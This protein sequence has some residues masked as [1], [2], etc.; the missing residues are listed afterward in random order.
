MIAEFSD[1][2][3]VGRYVSAMRDQLAAG[4]LDEHAARGAHAIGRGAADPAAAVLAA[5]PEHDAGPASSG[6]TEI[7]SPFFSRS[8]AVSLLQTSL[9][10]EARKSG[11]VHRPEHR[12]LFAHIVGFVE[13]LV[14][15]ERF[16][17]HDGEWVSRVAEATLDRLARGNHPFNSTPAE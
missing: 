13:S 9:E 11:A 4:A 17:P 2:D 15:P 5:L 7:T 3:E 16:G 12:G 6:E 10:D 1:E 14:H 8:P